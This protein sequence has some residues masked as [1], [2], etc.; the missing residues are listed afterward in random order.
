M[1]PP[2]SRLM[3]K[4][5]KTE[6]RSRQQAVSAMFEVW[7]EKKALME[8][9]YPLS[10]IRCASPSSSC[11]VDAPLRKCSGNV[12][13]QCGTRSRILGAILKCPGLRT[14]QTVPEARVYVCLD[15]LRQALGITATAAASRLNSPVTAINM[16]KQPLRKS[17]FWRRFQKPR[18]LLHL[19][20]YL[21]AEVS[22]TPWTHIRE[23]S[24]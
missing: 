10:A 24:W 5:S 22:S 20:G 7:S 16:H 13:L 21:C 3:Y 9:R 19:C 18:R 8:I 11:M 12:K 1:F 6:A 14:E 4:R 23:W 2:S 15:T 17:T